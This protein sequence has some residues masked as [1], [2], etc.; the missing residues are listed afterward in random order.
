[1]VRIGSAPPDNMFAPFTIITSDS[2]GTLAH[3][4]DPTIHWANVDTGSMVNIIYHGV[5]QAFP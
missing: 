1:M 2:K 3:T 5:V 4:P